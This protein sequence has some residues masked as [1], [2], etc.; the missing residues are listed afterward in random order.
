[1]VDAHVAA[2]TRAAAA[3]PGTHEVYIT[4]APDTRFAEPTLELMAS[5]LRL[6]DVPLRAP[7]VGN[8]SPLDSGKAAAR[9]GWAPRS[10]HQQQLAEPPPPPPPPPPLVHGIGSR[11]A[12]RA[13]ADPALRH[14]CIGGLELESGLRLPKHATLAYKV[15]GP[16][17]GEGRGVILHPTS[18]DAVHDELE[19]N[20]GPG[21]ALDTDEYT[22]RR[23]QHA[24]R[25]RL[26]LAVA[27]RRGGRRS[28]RAAARC[29]PRRDHRRQCARTARAAAQ[30]RCGLWTGSSRSRSSTATQ[31]VPCRP[32]SG[33][34][35]RGAGVERI[36]AVC[37]ASRCGELNRVFIR[38]LEAALTA[39]AGWNPRRRRFE[40]APQDGLRAFASIYAGWG[41]G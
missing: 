8:F 40:H 16:P 18:F 20:I 3:S 10:W 5:S 14:H 34:G 35:A 41:G 28:R 4:A 7:L 12:L 2:A 27:R 39:D 22:V 38:S 15:H 19:H 24:R 31:W 29:A 23:H 6:T 32:L 21:R 33:R 13:R 17:I 9:L 26:L 36:A 30:P 11:A 37:G 1:V 25:R